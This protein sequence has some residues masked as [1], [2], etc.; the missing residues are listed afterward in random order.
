MQTKHFDSGTVSG[1][2]IDLKYISVLE[3]L[4]V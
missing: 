4:F 2:A 3:N 1:A